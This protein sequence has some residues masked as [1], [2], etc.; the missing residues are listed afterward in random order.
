MKSRK[1]RD[2]VILE[3]PDL[4]RYLNSLLIK[5]FWPVIHSS[6]QASGYAYFPESKPATEWEHSHVLTRS[7]TFMLSDG[8]YS[9]FRGTL[10]CS[11]E[12]WMLRREFF[13]LLSREN[14]LQ[15]IIEILGN[16]R[17]AGCPPTLTVDRSLDKHGTDFFEIKFHAGNGA[18]WGYGEEY[19][20]EQIIKVIDVNPTFAIR[21]G[22]EPEVLINQCSH[23]KGLHYKFNL[24]Y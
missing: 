2:V 8:R 10:S 4:K 14:D 22:R 19:V 6:L 21:G 16:S 9:F 23:F 12:G 13:L 20:D 7:L 11:A 17:F 18:G 1:S 3:R 24:D 15:G 5:R